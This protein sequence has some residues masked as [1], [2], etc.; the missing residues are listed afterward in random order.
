MVD[1][2]LWKDGRVF[3]G[4]R[5]AESLLIEGDR[6]VAVGTERALRSQAPTGTVVHDLGGHLLLP[7]LIDA[8]LHVAAL[9]RARESFNARGIASFE[10]LVERLREWARERGGVS[11]VGGGWEVEQFREGRPPDREILDRA[12]EDRPVLLYHTSLHMAVTNSAALRAA[13]VDRTTP[14][15]PHGTLGREPDG[16]PNG[17][18]YEEA[19]RL[20]ASRVQDIAPPDPGALVRTL[21]ELAALGLTT[22]VSV[23]VGREENSALRE[24]AI[25]ERSPVRLRTYLSLRELDRLPAGGVRAE[26]RT[27]RFALLGVK[28]FTDGAF[29]PRTAWLSEPYSDSPADAG[30]PTATEEELSARLERAA[31]IG[32]GAAVHAIG[33]RALGQALRVLAPLA[34]RTPALARIEHAA[35]TPPALLPEL[36]RVRPALVVQPGF[37]WSD[38][39][40]PAR[41]GAERTRWAYAFRTLIDRGHLLAGSSDAPADP[42]DPWRGLAAALSRR[43]P[44]GR[45]ANPETAEALSAEE[46]VVLYTRNA[47]RV[48]GESDL[49]TLEPGARADLLVMEATDLARALPAGASGVIETWTG[50]RRVYARS[51]PSRR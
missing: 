3:T 12:V 40:L 31:G 48:L 49:G 2:H 32:L 35:L 9:V 19:V 13:T 44:L 22:V 15:P 21:G 33:D 8:H 42:V 1:A 38:H 37:V 45:S 17:L 6:V 20:V 29:G 36:D 47:G 26:E 18:L 4:L 27:D 28:A 50:G 51:G 41:L 30:L 16:T 34:G 5:Y 23:N 10:L 24:L 25:G 46:S 39:W 11:I 14:D 43:D 7:G